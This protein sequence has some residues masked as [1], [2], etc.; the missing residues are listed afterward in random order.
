MTTCVF[1]ASASASGHQE[2]RDAQVSS[3][4][5]PFGAPGE[6]GN[7]ACRAVWE[8]RRSSSSL[9]VLESL[10][11]SLCAARSSAISTEVNEATHPVGL[12]QRAV[13]HARRAE[14]GRNVRASSASAPR[15]Q[16][17]PRKLGDAGR[18]KQRDLVRGKTRVRP[19]ARAS[20]DLLPVS[21]AARASLPVALAPPAIR[22]LCLRH[23]EAELDPCI[24]AHPTR[25]SN[26]TSIP[27]IPSL[28]NHAAKSHTSNGMGG[29][30]RRFAPEASLRE[31]DSGGGGTC[32]GSAGASGTGCGAASCA[33]GLGRRALATPTGAALT[34]SLVCDGACWVERG[35]AVAASSSRCG[36]AGLV[37]TGEEEAR[38]DARPAASPSS[39]SSGGEPACER[40][41]SAGE[42]SRGGAAAAAA[43]AG[44]GIGAGCARLPCEGVPVVSAAVGRGG[45][46]ARK[47]AAAG[48]CSGD[49]S[50][51]RF[52]PP[53][54]RAAPPLLVVPSAGAF[55]PEPDR[56]PSLDE[57]ATAAAKGSNLAPSSLSL[58]LLRLATASSPSPLPAPAAAPSRSS[59]RR[60]APEPD[61]RGGCTCCVP[62]RGTG[63]ECA[64][65]GAGRVE[66]TTRVEGAAA[67]AGVWFPPAAPAGGGGAAYVL[68]VAADAPACTSARPCAT[69]ARFAGRSKA[70]SSS[71]CAPAQSSLTPIEFEGR[72]LLGFAGWGSGVRAGAGA[73]A[74]A[75]GEAI[76]RVVAAAAD[77][78]ACAWPSGAARPSP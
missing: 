15:A 55:A 41:D 48:A 44:A 7:A 19:S 14:S 4:H 5:V 25:S 71:P 61:P 13:E 72:E 54:P 12:V 42:S 78:P 51:A 23:R 17:D 46:A 62:A 43:G 68:S 34:A 30:L 58:S 2:P 24:A 50:R 16:A 8:G 31:Y 36:R 59:P 28:R 45:P 11:S 39:S 65:V 67:E 69:F 76:A 10:S 3:M 60:G 29:S 53:P 6:R 70:G 64:A 38:G 27:S 77:G 63:G 22:S 21:P 57:S 33:G 18:C 20:A 73:G 52:F 66:E 37:P 75:G 26:G 74:G 56:G 49:P 32:E 40:I 1:G 9:P 47:V 35:C